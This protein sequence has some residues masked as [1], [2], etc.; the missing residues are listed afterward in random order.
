MLTV[1]SPAKTLD[2]ET[3]PGTRKSTVPQLLERSSELVEDMR[4]LSPDDIRG[5]MGVSDKLAE[6]NHAR[7]MKE[8]HHARQEKPRT[9]NPHTEL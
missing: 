7:F 5:L 8:M 6:L 2:F 4:A 9:K 1:I 3:P